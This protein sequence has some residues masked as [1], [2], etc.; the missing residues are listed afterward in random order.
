MYI[1]VQ[2]KFIHFIFLLKRTVQKEIHR[3][4]KKGKEEKQTET[5]DGGKKTK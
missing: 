1:Y 2:D 5:V 3:Q 4:K